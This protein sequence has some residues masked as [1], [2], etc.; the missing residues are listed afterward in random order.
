MTKTLASETSFYIMEVFLFH[1]SH[2]M[3]Q[4][5]I[6]HSFNIV[7]LWLFCGWENWGP[8]KGSK[9]KTTQQL[10]SKLST[11]TWNLAP[12]PQSHH[13]AACMYG[14]KHSAEVKKKTPGSQSN[15]IFMSIWEIPHLL[16]VWPWVRHLTSLCFSFFTDC[17]EN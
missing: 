7:L 6:K 15:I 13:H 9:V 4:W 14:I 2:F 12:E 10:N 8:G 1:S 16:P 3:F 11:G 5:E 17:C